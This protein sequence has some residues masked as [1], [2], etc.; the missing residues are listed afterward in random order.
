[1]RTIHEYTAKDGAVTF[2]VRYKLNG[3]GG[4]LTFDERRDAAQ[5]AEM[6]QRLGPHRA[7]AVMHQP[8][9]PRTTAAGPTV[10]ET[11]KHYIDL[12][13]NSKTRD[14]YHRWLRHSIAP[15]LGHIKITTLNRDTIQRWLNEQPGA[16]ATLRRTH[17]LLSA[18]LK[19]AVERG[20]IPRNPASNIQ[21]PRRPINR[22]RAPMTP[23]FT[24]EECDII[25]A[26]MHPPL[27]TLTRMLFETG[28]RIGEAC[29]LTTA[30]INAEQCTIHITGSYSQG[31]IG[32]TKTEESDRLITITPDLM[33]ALDL[34]GPFV[35]GRQ[36]PLD[37]QMYRWH[38]RK[39]TAAL[40][41][42]RQGHP[43]DLRHAHATWLLD[44]GIPLHSVQKRLGH[45][46]VTTTLSMYGHPT[47]D[48]D[49]RILA[50][51]L[52]A[53]SGGPRE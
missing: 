27:R 13:P 15:H 30:Q 40:G 8:T 24:R 45:K 36:K 51:F 16:T 38:W 18:S 10:T 7:L 25:F 41:E 29:A 39:A 20:E 11:V 49:D 4:S 1:M 42:N 31:Q 23:P 26:A 46:N 3:R 44:A 52:P 28:I 9:E 50:M 14:I 2:R 17:R 5:F 35:F 12:K 47:V 22:K 53:P 43:H 48:G 6:I 32:L 34:T 19:A 33:A 21:I 37:P